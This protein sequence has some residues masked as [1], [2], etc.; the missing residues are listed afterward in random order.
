M[1]KTWVVYTDGSAASGGLAAG[2]GAV[3]LNEGALHSEVQ[4]W[5]RSRDSA[6]AEIKAMREAVASVP[7]GSRVL[8]YTDHY[9]AVEVFQGRASFH[10][11]DLHELWLGF[12]NEVK[13]RRLRV[14][15]RWRR[16][17]RGRWSKAAHRLANGA[18]ERA[19]ALVEA[20]VKAA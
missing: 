20:E 16:R 5:E 3:V 2:W 7:A 15:L 8:I 13:E 9:S 14:E 17:M 6:W 10:R 4:G 18:R 19:L 11:S 12:W 1:E